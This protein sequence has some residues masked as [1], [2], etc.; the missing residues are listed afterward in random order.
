MK[1]S[2]QEFWSGQP[3]PSPGYLPDP[4]IEHAS[5]VLQANSLP[6]KLP[7]KLYTPVFLPGEC[8]GWGAWW[9]P[10]MGSHRVRHDWGDLAVASW[11]LLSPFSR[12][13]NWGSKNV[14]F[15]RWWSYQGWNKDSNSDWPSS[16]L[17]SIFFAQSCK[18]QS[19]PP[20][21]P[22]SW[23]SPGYDSANNKL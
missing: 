16:E 4:G 13:R 11:I 6:S 7:G 9:L 12:W 23:I 2:R 1:F 22:S 10:S 18:T 21:S 15:L 20:S 17:R 8:Q 5:P 3:F 19:F 14:H